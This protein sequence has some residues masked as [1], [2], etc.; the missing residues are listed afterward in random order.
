MANPPVATAWIGALAFTF[1]IFFDFAGYSDMAIG[2]GKM[3]GFKFPE[4]FDLPYI[5]KSIT[6]FWRR[7]HITLSTWFR[8]YVY[9]PLGGNRLGKGRQIINLL[10]VWALTG[11]WHGASW[12]FALWGLYFGVILILEKLFILRAL[13]RLPRAVAHIYT[14][15]LVVLGWVIFANENF[16]QMAEY[17]KNLVVSSSGFADGYTAFLLLSN[18]V[19]WVLAVLFSTSLPRKFSEKTRNLAEKYRVQGALEVLTVA[20]LLI[21]SLGFM[22]GGDYNPFLYFRF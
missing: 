18:L 13:E 1:H 16:N 10:I 6:E 4:N 21:V 12:N 7:W 3:L 8:E 19:L 15:L 20:V 17:I 22:V 9:I 2:L 11:F 14:M 5:S